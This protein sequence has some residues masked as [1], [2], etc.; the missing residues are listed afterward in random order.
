MQGQPPGTRVLSET[1]RPLRE[2]QEGAICPFTVRDSEGPQGSQ[3]TPKP[4]AI[5]GTGTV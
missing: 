2:A 1:S 5:Q 4:P 3:D